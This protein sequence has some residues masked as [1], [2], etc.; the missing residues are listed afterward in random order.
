MRGGPGA[1][2]RQEVP[3]VEVGEKGFIF[4]WLLVFSNG[5][6]V[7]NGVMYVFAFFSQNTHYN[8][9]S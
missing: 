7:E 6:S 5:R 4:V 9:K 3:Y 2:Q 1:R 8:Y